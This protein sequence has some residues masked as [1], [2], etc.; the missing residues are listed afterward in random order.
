[1]I[2]RQPREVPA[3][4]RLPALP[5]KDRVHSASLT[6]LTAE[7][8]VANAPNDYYGRSLRRLSAGRQGAHIEPDAR[9]LPFPVQFRDLGDDEA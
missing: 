4:W 9:C 5:A 6:G 8:I 1:M 7:L 2:F 3:A